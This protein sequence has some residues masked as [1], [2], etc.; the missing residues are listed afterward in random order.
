MSMVGV[1]KTNLIAKVVVQGGSRKARAL[2]TAFPSMPTVPT[3]STVAVALLS[4][5]GTKIT[6]NAQK[7]LLRAHPC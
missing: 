4:A 1:L 7:D 3:I 5:K 6:A 2:P